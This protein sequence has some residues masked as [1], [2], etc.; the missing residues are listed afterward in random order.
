[1]DLIDLISLKLFTWD[2]KEM[3]AAIL[4]NILRFINVSKNLR[5]SNGV[6]TS[7]AQTFSPKLANMLRTGEL[8]HFILIF[9]TYLKALPHT[10]RI[11]E[12]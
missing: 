1:M 3:L 9:R 4:E 7:L 8:D 10:D 12:F 5:K 11:D 2:Q 6:N